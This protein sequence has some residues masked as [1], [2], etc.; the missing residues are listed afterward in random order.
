MENYTGTAI[1]PEVF[2]EVQD[3]EPADTQTEVVETVEPTE[4]QVGDTTPE[5]EPSNEPEKYNI[6]GVGEFTA[7]EI[8]E[9][10]NG[11]LRQSDYTRKTQELAKQ[12]EEMK[13]AT[14]LYEHLRKNP[15]LIEAI[16]QAEQNPN[17]VVSTAAPTPERQMLREVMFNQKAMEVDMKVS[18]LHQKYGDFNEADLFERATKYGTDDL[19]FVLKGILYD[20]ASTTTAVQSAKEQLK[21]ELEANRDVVETVVGTR[22]QQ[23][24]KPSLGLSE[25][26]KRIARALGLSESEYAKWK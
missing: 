6:P 7:D 13:E 8:K 14:A 23:N 12:R 20:S 26:E 9:M 25:D 17:S 1:D 4:T 18:Q 5:V 21:A 10:K 3:N 16:K 15:F 22:Q 2:A 11:G 19:E 24:K